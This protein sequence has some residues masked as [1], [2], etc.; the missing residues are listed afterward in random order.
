MTMSRLSSPKNPLVAPETDVEQTPNTRLIP[1]YNLILY[2]DDD[3][4]MEFVVQVLCKALGYAV[5]RAILFMLEA[6]T[7]GRAI[8][9]TGSRE[10]AELKLE[11]MRTFHEIRERDQANLGPLHCDIEP[12]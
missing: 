1:P 7:S 11:Q 5:E 6:H 12:A 3:H 2:N 8:V 9:W 4:S 10:V